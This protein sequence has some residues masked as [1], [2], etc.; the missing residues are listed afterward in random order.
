MAIQDATKGLSLADKLEVPFAAARALTWTAQEAQKAV[1]ADLPERFTIRNRF[2]QGGIRITPANK[3]DLTAEVGSITDFMGKHQEGG[4]KTPRR[5]HLAIPVDVKRTK[6]NIVNKA[7]RP[8]AVMQKP[9]VFQAKGAI[10]ERMGK[11]AYP[12]KRLYTLTTQARIAPQLKLDE[13]VSKAVGQ[14]FP[15]LFN[16]SLKA[17]LES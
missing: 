12:L 3:Q 17:A 11:G 7:N 5:R 1:Q 6:R 15:E 2:V 9:N 14:R 4:D 8:R 13:T 16:R 10:Y